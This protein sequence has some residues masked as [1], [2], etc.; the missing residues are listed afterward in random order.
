MKKLTF[1]LATL[2][3]GGMMLTGCKKDD[4]NNNNN[5]GGGETPATTTKTVV[6]KMDNSIKVMGVTMTVSPCFHYTFSYKDADGNMV[7]VNDPTLPWS[8]EI[9]VTP[10][11]EAQLKGKVT[12]DE[13]EIPSPVYF[14]RLGSITQDLKHTIE[15]PVQSFDDKDD[16]I[17]Y[18]T[19]SPQKLEYN[20]TLSVE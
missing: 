20:Y 15:E 2:L 10:P 18:I 4:P 11:F 12:Y 3:V 16:F 6:Y 8:K 14:G 9:T 17:E 1:L 5:N 7:E 19:D 13:S